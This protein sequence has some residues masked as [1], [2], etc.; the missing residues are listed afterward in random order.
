[1]G[2]ITQRRYFENLS[3]VICCYIQVAVFI[4]C[5]LV[6]QIGLRNLTHI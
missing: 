6:F 1:M 2:K 5:I 3:G 4:R